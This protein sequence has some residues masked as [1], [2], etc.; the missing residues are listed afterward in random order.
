MAWIRLSSLKM[1][2]EHRQVQSPHCFL[3]IQKAVQW[4]I[5]AR[6]W[7]LTQTHRGIKR[8]IFYQHLPVM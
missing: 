4:E 1:K 5:A 3:L 6:A 7:A 2:N 8:E